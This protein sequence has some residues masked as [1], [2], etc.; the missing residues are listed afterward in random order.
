MIEFFAVAPDEDQAFLAAWDASAPPGTTLHRAL[1]ADVR[2]RFVALPG[3][4]ARR[5]CCWSRRSTFPPDEE[6]RAAWEQIREAFSSRQGFVG[7]Q[8][9]EDAGGRA[10]VIV[11]W[12]SPLMYQ[13]AVRALGDLIAALPYAAHAALYVPVG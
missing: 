10:A 13:R 6:F 5:E 9:L 1:R 2:W 8:A 4:A 3:D 11:H 12:S 7:A